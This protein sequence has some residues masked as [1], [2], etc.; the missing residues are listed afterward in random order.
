MKDT[1]GQG[2]FGDVLLGE[3]R[4]NDV[5]VKVLK[6]NS[7][8]VESLLEEAMLMASLSHKNLGGLKRIIFSTDNKCTN[9][10]SNCSRH[11]WRSSRWSEWFI[12][13]D[14]IHGCWKFGQLFEVQRKTRSHQNNDDWVSNINEWKNFYFFQFHLLAAVFRFAIDVCSGMVYLE[15]KQLVHRDLAARNILLD[16]QLIAK[17]SD[18]GLAKP[19]EE[20]NIDANHGYWNIMEYNIWFSSKKN[21]DSN[22]NKLKENSQSNGPALKPSGTASSAT[23]QTCGHLEF[24]YGRSTHMG[25]CLIQGYPY[26]FHYKLLYKFFNHWLFQM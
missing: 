25:E 20:A 4:G 1:I 26:R 24:Y 15:E 13:G 3:Y 12:S 21:Y 10:Y 22:I 19:N 6:Q 9:N 11:A 18:F 8:V 7:A 23:N 5:A 16:S 14:W 17:I 2:E